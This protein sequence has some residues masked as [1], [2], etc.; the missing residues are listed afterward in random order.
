AARLTSP[1]CQEPVIP[2]R[3]ERTAIM[4]KTIR[5]LFDGEVLRPEEPLD[6]EPDTT[7]VV[8][9]ESA[10][11]PATDGEVFEHPLTTIGNLATDMGVTDLAD[12]H[13]YYANRRIKD[14]IDEP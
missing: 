11:R 9:I 10:P 5:V 4:L 1:R 13:D 8:T 14:S 7:Y 2:S 12:R 6:L 3:A